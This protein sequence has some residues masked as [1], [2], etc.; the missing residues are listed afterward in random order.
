MRVVTNENTIDRN[1][2]WAQLLF[3]LSMGA[4]IASFFFSSSIQSADLGIFFQCVVMPLLLVMVITSV[5]MTN[6]WV[7]EPAPWKALRE[8][9]KGIGN[10]AVLYHYLMPADH[11]L[12]NSAG[13][14]AITTRFQDRPQ[15][16]VDDKWENRSGILTYMRQEQLGDPT[17]EAKLKAKQT[18][19]F[20]QELLQDDSIEV[21]PLVVFTHPRASVEMEGEQTIPVLYASPDRK[22]SSIKSYLKDVAKK[23]DYPTLSEQQIKELD[24]ALLFEDE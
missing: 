23:T 17:R 4:L 18:E 7:R 8:G 1:K 5:R 3:F 24:D 2:R 9:L 19:V 12:V 20:L 21:Q 10:D 16:I 22:K 14:F 6:L 13:I 11:V 15:K